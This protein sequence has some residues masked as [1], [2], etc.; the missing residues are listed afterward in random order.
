VK[1]S[2]AALCIACLLVLSCTNYI[3]VPPAEY[4]LLGYDNYRVTLRNGDFI[5]ASWIRA[6]DGQFVLDDI[7]NGQYQGRAVGGDDSTISLPEAEVISIERIERND[8]LTMLVVGAAFV[9]VVLFITTRDSDP[10]VWT[11]RVAP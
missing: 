11:N 9:A 6:E 1:A 4:K 3:A 2:I 5:V 7:K 10:E 8:D